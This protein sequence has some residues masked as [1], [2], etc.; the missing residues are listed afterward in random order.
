ME[1][2]LSHPFSTQNLAFNVLSSYLGTDINGDALAQLI[3]LKKTIA[4]HKSEKK[5]VDFK[6]A[7]HIYNTLESIHNSFVRTNSGQTQ[8]SIK[9]NE[10][11]KKYAEQGQQMV[12]LTTNLYQVELAATGVS[13]CIETL[14]SSLQK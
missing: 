12:A 14:N 1:V 7:D 5:N 13:F 9:Y 8:L 11:E 2:R 3:L 10:L 6:V 4:N